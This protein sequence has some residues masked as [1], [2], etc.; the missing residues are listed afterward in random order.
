MVAL[1]TIQILSII[2]TVLTNLIGIL[3]FATDY[4]SIIVYDLVKFRSYAKWIV[5]EETNKDLIHFINNTNET[6]NLLELNHPL[7]TVVIGMEKNLLL[8]KTHKGIFRQ[9]NYLSE[10]MQSRLKISKCRLLKTFN[11]QWDDNIHGMNNP[12]REFIRKYLREKEI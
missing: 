1:L 11:N 12:G 6:Q 4:W 2:A 9:C 7:S 8:Y 5:I 10:N 3:T